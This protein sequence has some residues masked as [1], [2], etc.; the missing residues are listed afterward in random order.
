MKTRI[1]VGRDEG[2]DISGKEVTSQNE[3]YSVTGALY[4]SQ[5]KG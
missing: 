2:K 3:K 4:A 5:N 1:L